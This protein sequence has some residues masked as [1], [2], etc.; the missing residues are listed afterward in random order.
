MSPTPIESVR[1]V[2]AEGVLL[3]GGGRALLM[4]VAHPLVA[5]GVA[6]HSDFRRDR[7]GRLLRTLRPMYAIAFG[8]PEEVRAATEGVRAAHRHVRGAGYRADDPALLAWVLATL[9]DTSLLMHRRFI[10]PLG[11]AEAEAYYAG[12]A[13]V[14]V[15]LGMPR[16]AL[17]PRLAGFDAYVAETVATLEV[18]DAARAIAR[19]LFAPVPGAPW[20]T[21]AMP[22]AR[23][24]TAGL[25]PPRLRAPYALPW[26]P[27]R[28]ALLATVARATRVLRPTLPDHLV[29]PPGWLLPA[30]CPRAEVR[31]VSRAT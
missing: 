14:G 21:L 5:R 4:Q 12:M 26:G 18:G 30:S 7:L 23:A 9:I 15:A 2:N 16:E 17:P 19:E 24:L 22:A 1:A 27:R 25:L 31:T 8:T 20:L 28:E 11:E 29:A 6:D 3:L 13:E 10:G